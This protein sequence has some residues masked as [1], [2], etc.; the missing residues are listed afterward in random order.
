MTDQMD[1]DRNDSVEL[2]RSVSA[3]AGAGRLDAFLVQLR[4]G[5]ATLPK[6][7]ADD[8]IR[9]YEEYVADARMEGATEE[10]IL[11]RIGP[12]ERIVR[13]IQEELSIKAAHDRPSA[14]RLLRTSRKIYGKGAARA[15][16]S[17][18]FAFLSLFPLMVSILLYLV[19]FVLSL[20]AMVIV[21]AIVLNILMHSDLTT[22]DILAQSGL[23]AAL[24]SILFLVALAFRLA[25]NAAAR[26]TLTLFRK[27]A[28]RP[29]PAMK[30]GPDANDARVEGTAVSQPKRRRRMAGFFAVL[31]LITLTAGLILS[32]VYGLPQQ[33]FRVWNSQVPRQTEPVSLAFSGES[34]SIQKLAIEGL[35]AN[36]TLLPSGD[37]QFRLTYDKAPYVS[38]DWGQTGRTWRLEETANGRLPFFDWLAVHEGTAALTV[39]LPGQTETLELDIE[40]KGGDVTVRVPVAGGQIRTINGDITALVSGDGL[41]LDLIS[42]NGAISRINN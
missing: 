40:T 10:A 23:A 33:Y 11:S 3:P 15:V 24:A 18:S 1:Y 35:N 14:S 42:R 39:Y 13:S 28:A 41:S 6:G 32:F 5:L 26:A 8:A 27:V 16:K 9:Y 19:T 7:A 21:A 30:R 36:I 38:L 37:G 12:V 25:A 22:A 20:G 34:S 2:E 17:T 31:L 29:Q 4:Q